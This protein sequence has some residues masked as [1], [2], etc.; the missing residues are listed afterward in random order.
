MAN[1]LSHAKA[2][3]LRGFVK[4]YEEARAEERILNDRKKKISKRA[5][6][7]GL[8]PKTV[9]RV[10]DIRAQ[11]PEERKRQEDLVK[12]Y[13]HAVEESERRSEDVEFGVSGNETHVGL[14][15][16][17]A[18]ADENEQ[19]ES[20]AK[21]EQREPTTALEDGASDEPATETWSDDC[22]GPGG[23]YSII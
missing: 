20:L 7:A 13:L 6:D 21:I 8:H 18:G 3:K 9:R 1:S 23:E 4:E 5:N 2:D 16:R 11:D 12:S 19:E 17:K 14:P 15:A 10:V 22:Y